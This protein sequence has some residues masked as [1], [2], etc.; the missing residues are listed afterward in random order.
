MPLLG[1]V[2]LERCQSPVAAQKV[3]L[4]SYYTTVF[5]YWPGLS[6]LQKS[7]LVQYSKSKTMKIGELGPPFQTSPFISPSFNSLTLIKDHKI[8][9]SMRRPNHWLAIVVFLVANDNLIRL[10]N[11]SVFEQNCIETRIQK[12]IWQ[13]HVLRNRILFC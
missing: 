12:Q 2:G 6:R 11:K 8:N 1:R 7:S 3:F 5:M 4:T 10:F 9:D 13:N